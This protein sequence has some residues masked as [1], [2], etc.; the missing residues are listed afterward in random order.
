M[1]PLVPDPVRTVDA[2][3]EEVLQPVV[4]VHATAILADLPYQKLRDAVITHPTMAEGLGP[5]LTNV[6]PRVA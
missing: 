6:P 5:L 1:L 3:A 4:A 2:Q